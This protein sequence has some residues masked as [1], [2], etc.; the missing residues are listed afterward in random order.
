[1]KMHALKGNNPEMGKVHQTVHPQLQFASLLIQNLGMRVHRM[2]PTFL[3]LLLL[4]GRYIQ[5]QSKIYER[6]DELKL[7]VSRIIPNTVSYGFNQSRS[8][9]KVTCGI[10][11]RISG[12]R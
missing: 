11:F 6:Q 8:P 3:L 1:M 2:L 4:L 7:F 5:A 12:L 9:H 10:H